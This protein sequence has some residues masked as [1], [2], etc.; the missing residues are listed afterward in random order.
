MIA[1]QKKT[2]TRGIQTYIGEIKQIFN[3]KR[4]EATL[5]VK[6]SIYRPSKSWCRLWFFIRE[7]ELIL[8]SFYISCWPLSG[9]SILVQFLNG[10][11]RI[12]YLWMGKLKTPLFIRIFLCVCFKSNIKI[13]ERHLVYQPQLK[14][15]M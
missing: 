10:I 14:N 1:N 2:F 11:S 6:V 12:L 15:K 4:Q 8:S 3:S 7:A 9:K 5:I 13:G